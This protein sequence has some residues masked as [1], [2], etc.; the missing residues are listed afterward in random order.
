MSR[1]QD[2]KDYAFQ[3]QSNWRAMQKVCPH[4]NPA[5]DAEGQGKICEHEENSSG[6]EWCSVDACPFL[7]VCK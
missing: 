4:R 3:T 2:F 7:P 6:M 5:R 1:A